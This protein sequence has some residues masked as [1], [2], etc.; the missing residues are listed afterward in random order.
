[1]IKINLIYFNQLYIAQ[2]L[3]N[4]IWQD[5]CYQPYILTTL[6]C[7][8]TQCHQNQ[9]FIYFNQPYIVQSLPNPFGKIR[10]YQ[11]YI[12]MTSSCLMTQ[13]HQNQSFIYFNQPY[14]VQSLP[15]PIWKDK[16]VSA[17]YFNDVV[18]SDD[19]MSSESVFHIF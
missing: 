17:I 18:L 5:N 1:M 9:S 8:M 2:S 12:S 15:N 7:L 10:Q 4:L 16:A 3:P 13:C 19:T 14:I 6:S 11:P